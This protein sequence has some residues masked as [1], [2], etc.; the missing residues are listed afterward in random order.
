MTPTKTPQEIKT[1]VIRTVTPMVVGFVV[2]ILA[3]RGIEGDAEFKANLFATAQLL[4]SGVYYVVVRFI[5]IK[6]PKF[7][8]LLGVAKSPEYTTGE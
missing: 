2:A 1:S 7:G 8:I 4:V 3:A 5:E 6:Y